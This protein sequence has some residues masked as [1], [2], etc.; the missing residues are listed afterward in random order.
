MTF[1]ALVV[2]HSEPRASIR[3]LE[4][5]DLPVHGNVLV[6]VDWSSINYKD[7]MAVTGQGKI[8]RS[9]LPFVPGIDLA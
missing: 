7:A 6:R 9:E 4:R 1:N 5:N 2:D 3:T 8:I